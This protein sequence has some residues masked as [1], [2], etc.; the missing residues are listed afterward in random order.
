M[1]AHYGV[2]ATIKARIKQER[3][4]GVMNKIRILI[5]HPCRSDQALIEPLIQVLQKEE[6]CELHRIQLVFGDYLESY[7]N[8]QYYF[9][10]F[11]EI[12]LVIII[13]DRVEQLALCQCAFFHRLPICHY[14]SGITNTIATFDDIDRH[15]I[16]L[17]ADVCLCEDQNSAKLTK[18]LKEVIRKIT[19]DSGYYLK[20]LEKH[21]IYVVGNLYWESLSEIDE[22]LVPS[23]PYDLVLFNP[24]TLNNNYRPRI[25]V[26]TP[27][28][29]VIIGSNPDFSVKW[30]LMGEGDI[31]YKSVP[32]SQFLGLLKRCQRFITNSSSAYYEAMPLGLK[33]EQIV[34][35]GERNKNRSTPME[36][37]GQDYKSSERIVEIIRKWWKNQNE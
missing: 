2:N 5:S 32:R 8:C 22:S 23:E 4:S 35:I 7:K 30:T 15:V 13:G 10:N 6:W 20:D 16:S 28:I 11:Q 19:D 12:D 14:G 24:E 36:W 26:S 37:S 34:L 18:L 3:E 29:I 31:Y 33:R 9:E 17:Y 1:N 27:R 25:D 21:D